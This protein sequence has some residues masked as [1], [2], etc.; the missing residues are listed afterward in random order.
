VEHFRA[1]PC[2]YEQIRCLTRAVGVGTILLAWTGVSDTLTLKNG[3][4][5][6]IEILD[7]RSWESQTKGKKADTQ[8]PDTLD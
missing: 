4:A 7:R 3:N 1:G 6:K 5:F 2:G 8:E